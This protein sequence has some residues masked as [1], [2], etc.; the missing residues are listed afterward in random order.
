MAFSFLKSTGYNVGKSPIESDSLKNLKSLLERYPEKIKLPCD[1]I[2]ASSIDLPQKSYP[3]N[4]SI[5]EKQMETLLGLDIGPKTV[6]EFSAII[7]KVNPKTIFWNGPMGA[8]EIPEFS[9]G[10]LEIAKLLALK[11]KEGTCVVVGGGDSTAAVKQFGLANE[12]TH[13][14]T[15]GGASLE[16]L[17]GK[18]LPGIAVLED[19]PCPSPSK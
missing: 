6:K 3:V 1:C 18:S 9:T 19:A 12:M 13:V 7:K 8:F 17:E 4:F 15:G 10:T 2:A 5:V 14:L 11:A 16:F